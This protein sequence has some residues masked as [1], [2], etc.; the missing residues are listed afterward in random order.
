M[1]TISPL[2]V[3]EPWNDVAEGYTAEL[4]PTFAL[5][6]RDALDLADL[7]HAPT[8]LTWLPGLVPSPSSPPSRPR[9]WRLWISPR[10]WWRRFG[11]G[12]WRPA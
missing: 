11:I 3:P 1:A 2:S 8:C 5:Y 6:A 7:P 10:R 9:A 12:S 4:L